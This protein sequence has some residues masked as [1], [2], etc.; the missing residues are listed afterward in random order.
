MREKREGKGRERRGKEK[1]REKEEKRG[2]EKLQGCLGHSHRGVILE[3][4]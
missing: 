4:L 2:G 1:K 3:A